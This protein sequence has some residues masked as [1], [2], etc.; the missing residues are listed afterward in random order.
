VS[1]FRSN[2]TELPSDN[3][4]LLQWMVLASFQEREQQQQCAEATSRGTK[5]FSK[6]TSNKRTAR[7]LH[8]NIISREFSSSTRAK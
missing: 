3:D 5:V 1:H 6:R 7:Y 2:S 4:T 8:G